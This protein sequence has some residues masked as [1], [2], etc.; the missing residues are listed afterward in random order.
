MENALGGLLFDGRTRTFTGSTAEQQDE[1]DLQESNAY[2]MLYQESGGR[3]TSDLAI[4]VLQG[5]SVGGST[6]VNWTTCFR[7]P[8]RILEHWRAEHGIEGLDPQMLRP[9]FEALEARLSIAVAEDLDAG[10]LAIVAAPDLPVRRSFYV[11]RVR[12]TTRSPSARALL[13]LL[14]QKNRER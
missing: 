7:T 12:T 11:A 6:T 2:P 9:P 3:A 5:R 10:R 13:E 4:T 1:F 8:D 14:V